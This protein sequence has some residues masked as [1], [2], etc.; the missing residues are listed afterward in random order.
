MRNGRVS[1]GRAYGHPENQA[2]NQ[3]RTQEGRACAWGRDPSGRGPLRQCFYAVALWACARVLCALA[4]RSAASVTR[5]RSVS[6]A[7]VLFS[8]IPID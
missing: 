1:W 7:I 2:L 4:V 8:D 5:W 3:G 6:V